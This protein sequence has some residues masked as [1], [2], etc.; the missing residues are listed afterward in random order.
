VY[1]SNPMRQKDH[2]HSCRMKISVNV[3][4]NSVTA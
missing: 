4:V 2:P 1:I 3:I